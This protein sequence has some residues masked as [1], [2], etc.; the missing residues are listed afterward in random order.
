MSVALRTIG[1]FS[2]IADAFDSY[3]ADSDLGRRWRI[4]HDYGLAPS[5]DIA[6]DEGLWITPE[7]LIAL[8]AWRAR[9]DMPAL[10]LESPP[11]HWL[12]RLDR[13]LTGRAVITT[14]AADILG[15]S[16]MPAALGPRPWSQLSQG[17]VPRFRAARRDLDE[18]QRALSDAPPDSSITVS[19]HIPAISEEW[20]VIVNEGGSV[21]SS[22]Y[23]V[24]DKVDSH[25]ITTAFDGAQF[26][27]TCRTQAIETAEKAAKAGGL[28]RA[29]LIVAFADGHPYIIEAD[30]VWCTAPYPFDTNEETEA[31]LEAIMDCRLQAPWL[32]SHVTQSYVPRTRADV[33]QEVVTYTQT[34][35][36][37]TDG[38]RANSLDNQG[39]TP[40]QPDPWLTRQHC[41][42]YAGFQ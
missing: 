11:I 15:W 40:Y 35:V 33:A 18:L 2:W 26:D 9:R 19:G 10:L 17:R 5:T 37:Q 31:F 38:Q 32:E 22:G 28:K 14:S 12:S 39:P 4:T 42:R 41:R 6:D 24:H 13:S 3:L 20:C 8:N 36:I 34:D 16:A 7:S 29:S 25:T 23:C 1:A 27:E 30:P 21:A